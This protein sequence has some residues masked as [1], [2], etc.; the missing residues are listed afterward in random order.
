MVPLIVSIAFKDVALP[1]ALAFGIAWYG[2]LL[3][4]RTLP[5][6]SKR[7]HVSIMSS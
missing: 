4:F 1:A 2:A 5:W 6:D 3:L 7:K